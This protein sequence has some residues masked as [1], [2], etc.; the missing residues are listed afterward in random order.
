MYKQ[1]FD[2]ILAEMEDFR[3]S[4]N[5]RNDYPPSDWSIRVCEAIVARHAGYDDRYS[6]KHLQKTN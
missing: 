6:W 1:I 2:Q 4:V 3:D 5:K